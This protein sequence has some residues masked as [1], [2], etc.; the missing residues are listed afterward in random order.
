M[1]KELK[2][3]LIDWKFVVVAHVFQLMSFFWNA[4]LIEFQS[5][6]VEEIIVQLCDDSKSNFIVSVTDVKTSHDAH[7]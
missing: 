7:D 1:L 4:I 6:A 2:L 5:A 3:E